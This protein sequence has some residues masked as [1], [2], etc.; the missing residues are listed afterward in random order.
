MSVRRIFVVVTLAISGTLGLHAD[1]TGQDGAARS[2]VFTLTDSIIGGAAGLTVDRMGVIYAATFD[3]RVYK[4]RMDAPPEV[5]ASGLYGATGNVIGPMGNLYQLNFFGGYITKIDRHGDQEIIAT[6]LETPMSVAL[7]GQDLYVT[8]CGSNTIAR[9]TLEGEVT[10]LVQGPPFNCPNGITHASDGNLYVVNFSDTKLLRVAF[11]GTVSEFGALPHIRNVITSARGYLY[12]ASVSGR[13]LHRVSLT[14]GEISHIAGT[15]DVGSRDGTALEATFNSPNGIAT[16]GGGSI[17][18]HDINEPEA[19]AG[20]RS[21]PRTGSIRVVAV[22]SL[23]GHLGTIYDSLGADAM[24]Q[25]Y[26]A[27]RADPETAGLL[28]EAEMSGWG[29][30]TLLILPEAA[31]KIFELNAES[32]PDSWRVYDALGNAYVRLGQPAEAIAAFER[33]LELNADNNNAAE[34]LKELRG[35]D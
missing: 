10:T 1:L 17:F 6:G 19:T 9:V 30:Q 33:S 22:P 23:T 20:I 25:E 15:G 5:F 29:Y 3:E 31:L 11:D 4:V 21:A 34:K 8:N 27:Y 16:S 18:I 13:Q 2:R 35:V 32:Y 7:A 26:H 28:D 24:V 14:T 12:V